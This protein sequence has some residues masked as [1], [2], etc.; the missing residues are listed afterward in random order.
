MH[1]DDYRDD[2]LE[3]GA[4]WDLLL[5]HSLG[6][7]VALA[8]LA[9]RPHWTRKLILEEPAIFGRADSAIVEWLL[10][11]FDQ[12]LTAERVAWSNP[13]WHLRDAAAKAQA[14]QQCGPEAVEGTMGEADW[15]LWHVI[16]KLSIP[17]LLLAA[18]PD[19]TALIR[20]E[21][22]DAAVEVNPLISFA[23]VPNGDHSMHRDEYEAFWALVRDFVTEE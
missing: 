17:T 20:P 3:L 11:D 14:L 21:M 9:A 6:G 18:D 7:A 13:R 5:G 8:A 16:E 10:A 1:L 19:L 12:P 4:E 15:D 22:G 2:V 23:T